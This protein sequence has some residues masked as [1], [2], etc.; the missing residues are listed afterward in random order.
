VLSAK[1]AV[2]P[3]SLSPEMRAA[4]AGTGYFICFASINRTLISFKKLIFESTADVLE[5]VLLELRAADPERAATIDSEMVRLTTRVAA[6]ALMACACTKPIEQ[7]AL[8]PNEHSQ[9]GTPVETHRPKASTSPPASGMCDVEGRCW[10]HA[11]TAGATIRGLWGHG[12]ELVVAVGDGGLILQ[13]DGDGQWRE[14]I[15]GTSSNLL[16]VWGSGLADIH[17]VGDDGVILRGDG[18][19]WAR[20]TSPTRSALSSVWGTSSTNIYAVGEGLIRFDGESW[21]FIDAPDDPLLNLLWGRSAS[22]L[23]L[24]AY[25]GAVYHYDGADWTL[26]VAAGPLDHTPSY[27]G[28]G[29][30]TRTL[31]GISGTEHELI[32][33]GDAEGP[34]RTLAVHVP[35]SGDARTATLPASIRGRYSPGLS[36]VW[37]DPSGSGHAVGINGET[38]AYDGSSWSLEETPTQASLFAIWGSA[39][40]DVYAAGEQA[41]ILHYDGARWSVDREPAQSTRLHAVWCSS[42]SNIYAVGRELLRFDGTAWTRSALPVSQSLEALWGAGP[43][44]L[45]AVGVDGVIV[46]YENESWAVQDS[47]VER[48]LHDVWGTAPNDVYAVGDAGTL[49]HFDGRA[50]TAIE[51]GETRDLQAVWGTGPRDVFV[52]GNSGLVLHFDGRSW[53]R[54]F[55]PNPAPLTAVGGTGPDHVYAIGQSWTISRFDGRRWEAV[56]GPEPPPA[57]PCFPWP[58]HWIDLA[59]SSSGHAI[60]LTDQRSLRTYPENLVRPSRLPDIDDMTVCR[61]ADGTE[62]IVGVGA[63]EAVIS[64]EL[65]QSQ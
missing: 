65:P 8:A 9:P 54:A 29:H 17:I 64:I 59:V 37:L 23:Y 38:L 7:P 45:F 31:S 24:A 34:Y 1:L 40:N 55:T 48:S 10:L 32:V 42:A 5:A 13:R 52:V 58:E 50:W 36:A 47:G 62:Y 56:R 18:R 2:A 39:P 16:A 15:S 30:F 25:D 20:Q 12:R 14:Q 53:T 63:R 49:L 33:V 57:S 27:L 19:S 21:G 22:D 41:Q 26:S 43:S 4:S 28:G 61:D 44:E 11:A 46:H 35:K 6:L 51:I 60:M 3:S